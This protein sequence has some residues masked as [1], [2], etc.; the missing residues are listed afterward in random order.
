MEL[1]NKSCLDL[2][3]FPEDISLFIQN[4]STV[5]K[6]NDGEIQEV[7]PQWALSPG[8]GYCPLLF[9]DTRH[10]S[11]RFNQKPRLTEKVLGLLKAYNA[12]LMQLV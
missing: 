12:A 6:P 7:K 1:E 9:I 11:I 2:Y 5:F 10:I 8:S 3:L 4:A